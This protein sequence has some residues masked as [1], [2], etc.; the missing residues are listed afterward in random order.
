[1]VF[2]F[3]LLYTSCARPVTDSDTRFTSGRRATSRLSSMESLIYF[4][5]CIETPICLREPGRTVTRLE[6]R[7]AHALR[8]GLLRSLADGDHGNDRRYADQYPQ[9]GE[10][11]AHLVGKDRAERLPEII[12]EF[13]G[14][15]I[16]M[17][18]TE[19]LADRDG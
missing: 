2:Q 5:D 14:T 17:L 4:P 6:P 12:D 9:H 1:M 8:Y 16:R 7:R 18:F 19:Y 10:E 3:L 15:E 13:R 11:G